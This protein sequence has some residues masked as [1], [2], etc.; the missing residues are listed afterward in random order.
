MDIPSLFRLD[1]LAAATPLIFAVILAAILIISFRSRAVV[2]CQY[3]KRMTGI[4]LKPSEVRRVY[5]ERG[6]DGV[7]EMFLDLLIRQDLKEGPLKIPESATSAQ[8]ETEPQS[9]SSGADFASAKH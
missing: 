3:L 2:F 7:R 5:K 8:L 6:R 9:S 1:S 4:T